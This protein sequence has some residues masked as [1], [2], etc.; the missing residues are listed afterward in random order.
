MVTDDNADAIKIVAKEGGEKAFAV[1]RQKLNRP[2]QK[3]ARKA[4]GYVTLCMNVW[5]GSAQS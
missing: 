5:C 4:A 2:T 1:V 3:D